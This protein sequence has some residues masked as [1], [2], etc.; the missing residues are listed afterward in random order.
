MPCHMS[1]HEIPLL[2]RYFS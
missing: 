1:L 2:L